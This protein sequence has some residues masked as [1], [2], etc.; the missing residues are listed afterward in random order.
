MNFN[1]YEM[2]PGNFD[3]TFE[4]PGKPR[5]TCL[6]FASRLQELTDEEL[7]SRQEA[8][9]VEAGNRWSEIFDDDITI[10]IEIDF[11]PIPSDAG[12][13]ILGATGTSLVDSPADLGG[14]FPTF[15][16]LKDS[17]ADD[18]TSENDMIAVDNLP[19]GNTATNGPPLSVL[20]FLTNDRAGNTVLDDDTSVGGGDTSGFNNTLFAITMANAKAL[21]IVPG[22]APGIDATITF[23][24]SVSFDFDPSDGITPG[25]TDF[26]GVATHEI[27]HAMGFVSGVDTVDTF[28]GGGPAA[29]S[30][31][32]G[33]APGIGTLDS[34]ALFSTADLFRR[35]AAAFAADPDAL[36]FSTGSEVFFSID[37][38]LSDG[39][40]L[41][42]ET[43]SFNGTGQQASHFLDRIP[44]LGILD[45]TVAPGELLGI[46]DNDIL[47]LDVIGYDVACALGDL[48]QD[49]D[50]NFSDISPFIVILTNGG[51]LKAADT[52]QDGEVNF[53]DISPFIVLIAQ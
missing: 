29:A 14:M 3:E 48:N 16:S 17:L 32:N 53:F 34:F 1:N 36:D 41:L 26:I 37:G 28:T 42:M 20:S 25:T 38:D 12:A 35:S 49:G 7:A 19:D 8:G 50:V 22:D 11:G 6:Q 30:D 5:K 24:S 21:G 31:I 18:A 2:L 52:N 39:D 51:F 44:T 47:A 43:G 13:T 4:S 10:N 46:S 40:D 9:F 33:F 23:N 15:D 45:P 27:G